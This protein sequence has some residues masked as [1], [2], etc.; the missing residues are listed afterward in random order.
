MAKEK[1][2]VVKIILGAVGDCEEEGLQPRGSALEV[3]S[4]DGV[5]GTRFEAIL[6]TQY[7]LNDA[8]TEPVVLVEYHGL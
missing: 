1:R 7:A 3:S 2:V 8:G 5:F 6:G 4:N